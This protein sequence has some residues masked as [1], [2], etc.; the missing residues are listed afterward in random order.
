MIVRAF[1]IVGILFVLKNSNA[2]KPQIIIDS[3]LMV[4]DSMQP[5]EKAYNH[6]EIAMHYQFVLEGYDSVLIYANK[7]L[8]MAQKND[9]QAIE[10]RALYFLGMAEWDGNQDFEKAKY[11][12]D[13]VKLLLI[14]TEDFHRVHILD[15]VIA[16]VSMVQ[17][18]Y[19]DA[20]LELQTALDGAL[21]YN[22]FET[23]SIISANMGMIYNLNSDTISAIQ[24]SEEALEYLDTVSS[25]QAY[26]TKIDIRIMLAELYLE[27]NQIQKTIDLL[28]T[29][30]TMVDSLNMF[31]PEAKQSLAEAK[32]LDKQKKY[33]ELYLMV[34]EKLPLFEKMEGFDVENYTAFVYFRG[35]EL[36][37]K[38]DYPGATEVINNLKKALVNTSTIHKKKLLRYIPE[39][40]GLIGAYKDAYFFLQKYNQLNDSLTGLDQKRIVLDLKNKY[41][42]EKKEREIEQNKIENLELKKNNGILLS[43]L[44]GL[45]VMSLVSYI[46]YYRRRQTEMAKINRIEQK[47]L[48]LQMNPHFIF[49]AISSIQNYLF[50]EGDSKKAI[51]H[52]STFATLMRQ[53]LEN[54]RERFIPLEE[55]IEFIQ[56][57]LNL[58][59]LRFDEKFKYEINISENID[60]RTICIPPLLTQ[61]FIE[62]AIDHGMLYSVK[63]GLLK[64]NIFKQKGDLIIQ[65]VDNGV[66]IDSENDK[67]NDGS[68]VIKKKSLSIAITTERLH[69][70]SKLMKKKF[71]L[72]VRPNEAGRGTTVNL[73]VPAIS[74]N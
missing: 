26:I 34:N 63:D 14:E 36:G 9:W 46:W 3:L 72:E 6:V 58:Q 22:D 67:D 7:A 60:T 49:N 54:S 66:G 39:L 23:M 27:T 2:Q 40:S 51:Q 71:H 53:I 44:L 8:A 18:R 19:S 52:L 61:P 55:E 74:L 64:I 68:L 30:R 29:S 65:I 21:K 5:E 33:T 43:T 25:P 10:I 38:G 70:L 59:K 37:E 57:Y 31:V 48:S 42:T 69:L 20:L 28:K 12:F 1:I 32:L 56:N 62:N 11:Y 35:R 47:M 17:G 73:N 16:T 15:N 4:L 41:E 50:E 24:I 45:L 13:K